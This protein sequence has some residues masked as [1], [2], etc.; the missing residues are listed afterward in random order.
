MW[1]V[2]LPTRLLLLFCLEDSSLLLFRDMVLLFNL[3]LLDV[4]PMF[5]YDYLLYL[6]SVVPITFGEEMIY[7]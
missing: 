2:H 1:I 3:N 6:N 7:I 4:L 5:G